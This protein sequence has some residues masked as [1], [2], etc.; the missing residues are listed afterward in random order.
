M[1]VLLTSKEEKEVYRAYGMTVYC[2]ENEY[3]WTIYPDR[4]NDSVYTAIRIEKDGEEFI[5]MYLGNVCIDKSNFDRSIDN[6]LWW[7]NEDKP[8]KSYTESA[9]YAW[10]T[11]CNNF[12]NHRIESRKK[13]GNRSIYSPL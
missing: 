1:G 10:L 12:L 11:E 13:Y 7:I 5:N 9:V 6:F 8:G 4:P 2:V 3:E